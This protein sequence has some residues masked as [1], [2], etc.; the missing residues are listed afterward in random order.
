[1]IVFG[2]ASHVFFV[3]ERNR[4]VTEHQLLYKFPLF[5]IIRNPINVQAPSPRPYY[6]DT[7]I[8][9]AC[10]ARFEADFKGQDLLI[11]ILSEPKWRER[12]WI[13][14]LYGS[15]PDEKYIRG[16]VSQSGLEDKIIF[17]GP[18]NNIEQI[19]NENQLLV[20]PSFAEG[21][22]ISLVEAFA[23]GKVVV[24]T[25]V[26][27]N[28]EWIVNG[29]NGYI[30]DYPEKKSFDNTLE[31]C[32]QEQSKWPEIGM[33]AYNTFKKSYSE[34]PIVSFFNILQKQVLKFA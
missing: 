13:L 9:L 15:G 21:T 22:P 1:M 32:W 31:K 23:C 6:K 3:S 16:L 7:L 28:S 12:N 25:N 8:K 29:F 34:D 30:A 11:N 27:G 5:T 14:N 24:T 2:S 20:L 10:V 18:Q 17:N 33:N 4:Q 26:G 19:W